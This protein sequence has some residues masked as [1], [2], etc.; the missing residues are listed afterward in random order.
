MVK[1]TEIKLVGH[2]ILKQ[3]LNLVDSL[4]FKKVQ[5]QSVAIDITKALKHGHIL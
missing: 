3:V 2:P 1:N 4:V 5:N